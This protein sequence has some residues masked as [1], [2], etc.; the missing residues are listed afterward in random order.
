MAVG[1]LAVD[2][3]IVRVTVTTET[4]A[5]NVHLHR[6]NEHG[7]TDLGAVLNGQTVV[8]GPLEAADYT[9]ELT[10]VT[11]DAIPLPP[12]FSETVAAV[13]D[14]TPPSTVL[15]LDDG[16]YSTSQR[17]VTVSF[18]SPSEPLARSAGILARGARVA[19]VASV[20]GSNQP[21]R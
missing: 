14:A 12:A 11:S 13:E 1:A 18:L 8:D 20:R 19:G 6:L 15:Q 7:D 10:G 4:G 5:T 9:Y 16:R 3:H 21:S 17:L 2:G